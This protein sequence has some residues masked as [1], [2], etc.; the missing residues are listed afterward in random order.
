MPDES[1]GDGAAE[2]ILERSRSEA[3]HC[4]VL[5]VRE[6][7]APDAE[8]PYGRDIERPVFEADLV[9]TVETLFH[10][11]DYHLL[12]DQYYRTTV[13][14]SAYEWRDGGDPTDDGRYDRL[15]GRTERFQE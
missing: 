15:V 14:I 9:D 1:L 12:L 5:C 6:R 4:R 7:S 10:R 13:L 8:A 11:A 2:E 3:S